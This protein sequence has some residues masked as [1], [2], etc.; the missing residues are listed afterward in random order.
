MESLCVWTEL[1][2]EGTHP[3]FKI[4]SQ[5]EKVDRNGINL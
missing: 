3:S 5:E 2:Q 4:E 1:G